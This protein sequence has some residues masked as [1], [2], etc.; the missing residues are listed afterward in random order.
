MVFLQ[1]ETEIQKLSNIIADLVQ[2]VFIFSG[3]PFYVLQ[4]FV[5]M[6]HQFIN[7][8]SGQSN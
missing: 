4:N 7:N 1:V 6:Y 5:K 2:T 3:K 8:F